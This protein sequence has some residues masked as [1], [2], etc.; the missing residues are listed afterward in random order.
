M[1]KT[2][3]VT[4]GSRG[5][6][7]ATA[8]ELSKM[9][10]NIAV[11]YCGNQA[12]A[13]ETV[14]ACK[15]NGVEAIAIK[16]DVKMKAD[17]EVAVENVVETFGSIDVLVNNA[18]ITKDGLLLRMSEDDF[19]SVIDTN[20]KGCFL[21]SKACS[22]I[23]MKQRA[24]KIINIASVVGISGNAGQAN[25][26]ASKA[27]IIGFTKSLAKELGSRGICVNAVAPGF[28]ETDMT[29][30]LSDKVKEALM[31]NIP[32]KRTAKPE[33]IANAIGFLASEKADYI[34]GQVLTVDGGMC[35]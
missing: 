4:G 23:M 35:M 34:T 20:L 32:L 12:K 9:G 17:V 25:Y 33:D 29:E 18:G 1:S 31:N 30:V 14:A 3:I 2:A 10:M 22:S 19:D 13:E 11:I 16:C 24:G 21:F 5:I 15:E 26:A 7:R 8:I 6:G 27:G 28:V